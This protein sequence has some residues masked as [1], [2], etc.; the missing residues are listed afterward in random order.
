MKTWLVSIGCVFVALV[1]LL[2]FLAFS[3][4]ADIPCQDGPW[5]ETRRICVP[6]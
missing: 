3:G 4:F 1:A 6:T 2:A 5:D